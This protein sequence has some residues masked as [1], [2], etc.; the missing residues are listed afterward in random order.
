MIRFQHGQQRAERRPTRRRLSQRALLVGIVALASTAVGVS[1]SLATPSTR[2]E[3][4]C[5]AVVAG[6]PWKVLPAR[7]G[8]TY[9]VS[10]RNLPCA[11]ARPWVAR[12]SHQSNTKLGQVFKGPGGFTCRSFSTPVTGDHLLYSGVCYKGP[13]NNPFFGWGPKV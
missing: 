3:T 6:A 11:T 8:S 9:T 13:H 4:N 2:V 5:K 1:S 12:L 10:A 7:S